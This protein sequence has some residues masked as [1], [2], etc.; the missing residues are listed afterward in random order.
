MASKGKNPLRL[1]GLVSQ[2]GLS[3]VIPILLST[4]IGIF[5]DNRTG[6]SPLFLL[7]FIVVGVGAAFR[8]LF[9]IVNKEIKKEKQDDKDKR[10]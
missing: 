9:Q 5:L 10:I 2:L 7:L 6:L 1:I 8:N 3:M 4:F